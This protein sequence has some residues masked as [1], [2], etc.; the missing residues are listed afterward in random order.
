MGFSFDV[1]AALG[2]G[3]TAAGGITQGVLNYEAQKKNL[4]YQKDLQNQIFAREDTSMQRRIDDLKA[5][6]LSP[7]L[8]AGGS[9]AGAGSVVAT[10]APRI[11]GLDQVGQSIANAAAFKALE[12]QSIAIDRTA[13]EIALIKKQQVKADAD[14][15]LASEDAKKAQADTRYIGLKADQQKMDNDLQSKTGLPS[16]PSA[17]AKMFRDVYGIYESLFNPDVEKFYSC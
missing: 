5:A 13:E 17:P 8:A 3:L 14:A 7:V 11:E 6:G 15:Y 2:G 9:G 16:S 4:R 1:G 10:S 12:Q